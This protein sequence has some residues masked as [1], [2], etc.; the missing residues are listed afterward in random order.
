MNI[1]LA[2]KLKELRKTKNISQEKFAEYLGVSYQAVSKWENGVTSPD[3]LLL[4]DIARYFGIT[5]DELLQVEKLDADRCFEEYGLRADEL[6]R[7][8]KRA[9]IIPLWQEA[10]KKLP[11]D[12]RV[13]EML[14]SI[15]FD[16]DKVK[17]QNE[18][19]ELGTEIYNSDANSYYKGQAIKEVAQTYYA[20]GNS[21]KADEWARKAY[22][23]NH[24]QEMLYMQINDEED[25]LTDTFSFANHW[26]MD[27]LFYMAARLNMCN[28]KC[29]GDDYVQKV[30]KA[31]VS[32]F[33]VA[34]PNDDMGY[35]SLQHLCILH[36]CIAEDETTLGNNEDVVKKHLTRAVECAVKS[37]TVKAHSLIHPLLYGWKVADAPSDNMQIVRTLGD[38]LTWQC[39]DEYRN[40]D[41]FAEL[42]ARLDSAE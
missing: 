5:V 31:V 12:V 27:T 21:Q 34:Y 17:Y 30:N 10:Y 8:G 18:I 23:I 14:M 7:N 20:N 1:S 11:N 25:C 33:E 22:Q 6:F 9:E 35:E 36:R 29:F 28:V 40:K 24:C 38:E 37:T 16:T 42:L 32:M 39:F 19:I 2:D 3:I 13:K 26:Y 4:P 15:Y 41:W